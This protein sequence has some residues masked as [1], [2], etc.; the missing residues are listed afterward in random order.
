MPSVYS[1][2]VSPSLFFLDNG[3]CQYHE[4]HIRR[5]YILHILYGH[6]YMEPEEFEEYLEEIRNVRDMGRVLREG[7]E[8]TE[9]DRILTM[10]TCIASKPNNRFLVQGVLLNG[11]EE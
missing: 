2:K 1:V 7:V 9:G 11:E 10:S 8:V 3:K 6:D 5:E 4:H